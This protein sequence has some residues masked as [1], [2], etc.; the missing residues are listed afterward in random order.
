MTVKLLACI[1]AAALPLALW[2]RSRADTG[3]AKCTAATEPAEA[4]RLFLQRHIAWGPVSDKAMRYSFANVRL[5]GKLPTQVFVYLTGPGWCGSGGCTA[6]LLAPAGGSFRVIDRFTLAR[7][8]IYV[9]PSTSHG[10]HDLTMPVGGGGAV[11]GHGAL[12]R[13]NGQEYPTNPSTAPV[14]PKGSSGA[15]VKIPLRT[16]GCLVY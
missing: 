9:L 4:L 12:L 16:R 2:T 5:N 13:F 15:A 6:L 11:K 1:V 3:G 8:P 7:L 14:A 10:W